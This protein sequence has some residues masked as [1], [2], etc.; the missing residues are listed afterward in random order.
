MA[1]T[2]QELEATLAI[3]AA[4]A[5]PLRDAGIMGRVSVGD[6]HFD[7]TGESPLVPLP[8]GTEEPANPIDDADTYGGEMP[9]R[10][11]AD[12]GTED[13]D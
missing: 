11:G 6:V 10:K 13:E 4:K 5:K 8:Q 1:V 9:R 2:P 7:L 3:I 12:K